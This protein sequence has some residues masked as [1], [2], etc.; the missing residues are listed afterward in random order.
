MVVVSDGSTDET[1]EVI[2]RFPHATLVSLPKSN[3]SEALNE[4]FRQARGRIICWL[5]T[6]DILM[7]RAFDRALDAVVHQVEMQAG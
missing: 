3:Q 5:N 1:E 7:P 2:D 6:D 4:G